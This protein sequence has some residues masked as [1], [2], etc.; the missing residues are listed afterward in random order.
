MHGA[1]MIPFMLFFVSSV[2]LG[3]SAFNDAAKDYESYREGAYYLVNHGDYT[4]VTRVQHQ[5]MKCIEIAGWSGFVLDIILIALTFT[6]EKR[7]N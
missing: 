7:K 3:G 6:R 4:E 2:I 1:L 5:Y